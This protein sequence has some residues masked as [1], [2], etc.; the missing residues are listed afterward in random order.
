MSKRLIQLPTHFSATAAVFLL[1]LPW[2]N[3]FAPGPSPGVVPWL[4]ALAGVASLLWLASVGLPHTNHQTPPTSRW[5]N[6]VAAAWLLAGLVSSVIGLLQYFGVAGGLGQ[7]VNQ[8]NFGEAFANLRQRNQFA[9]LTNIALAALLYVAVRARHTPLA[10][11]TGHTALMLATASLLAIGNAV[12]SSRTGLFQLLLICGMYALWG[13]LRSLAVQR[14][15]LCAVLV[16]CISMFA[17]PWLA[18]LDAASYGAFSRLGKDEACSS[19]LILWSN[20]LHLIAQKPWL[21]WGWGELDYAHFITLYEGPRFCDIL[22]N[23]HN[24]PLHLAV[25][26]GVPFALLICG[27]FVWWVLRQKPWAERDATRQMAWTVT[28]V[29]LLHSMLE[30]PLWYG[31]FQMAAGLCVIMLWRRQPAGRDSMAEN[32]GLK[33]PLAHILYRLIAINTIVICSYTAWDYHRISQL[34]LAPESRNA[35][36]RSDTLAKVRDSWLFSNQV[37]FAELM[38]TALEPG[39]AVWTFEAAGALL[40]YSPEP[41]VIEKRIEAAVLLGYDADALEHLARYKA[42]FPAEHARWAKANGRPAL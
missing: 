15:L 41:R 4:V 12:S 8:T 13:G 35:A 27:G 33:W 6:V 32:R 36:Y 5:A 30:Y 16:Y 11:R 24:L 9:T 29:I 20:V 25:E 22:D 38:L 37:Q 19:R 1:A 42:A 31:P 10:E 17:A 40:H 26:L 34:Y 3:P 7:W 2:L 21:G 14:L 23:A 18:G 28:A 39:N